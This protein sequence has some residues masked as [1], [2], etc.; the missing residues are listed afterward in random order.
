[1]PHPPSVSKDDRV[2]TYLAVLFGSLSMV[3][4]PATATRPA[5]LVLVFSIPMAMATTGRLRRHRGWQSAALLIGVVLVLSV[6]TAAWVI[7]EVVMLAGALVAL[8]AVGRMLLHHDRAAAGVWVTTAALSF[9]T[10]VVLVT[11]ETSGLGLSPVFVAVGALFAVLR[12][13]RNLGT[14]P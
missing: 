4:Y 3:A 13:S 9:V 5:A 12:V 8:F 2:L 10:G 1:M 11:T 6:V 14:T 7:L